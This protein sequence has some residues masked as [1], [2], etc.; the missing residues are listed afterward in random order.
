VSNPAPLSQRSDMV[1]FLNG[2]FIPADQARVGIM[3]HAFS[4]G[5]GCFEGIR[6]YWNAQAGEN[7]LFRLREHFERLHR[8]A[9]ILSVT[10]PYSVDRLM[11]IA[12]ELVRRNDFRENCYLRPCAFKADETIGVKLHGLEDQFSMLAVPMGDYVSTAGL[13][14]GVSSWRRIDDNMIPARGKITGAYVNSA[15]AKSEAQQNG[16]DEAIMLTSEGHVSEGSAEN[17]FLL[18]GNELV[19][20]PPTE[21]I[22]LGITRETVMQL[23]RRELEL[24][25]R[26]RVIDRTELYVADEIILTGTGAQL[27]PVVAVDHRPVGTGEIGPVSRELQRLYG[28]VVRGMRP[29]YMGWLTP[30]FGT[31]A[32]TATATPARAPELVAAADGDKAAGNGHKADKAD[33]ATSNGRA[34]GSHRAR[35]SRQ[36]AATR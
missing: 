22:L 12:V 34:A 17:I 32:T 4:Y 5:T 29:E 30:V 23:A 18:F 13:R 26:E 8:S 10:L 2:E 20:P 27:A 7:Y 21:N 35:A 16:F 15:F 1:V 19:T 31:A 3:S 11:E 14:C 25:V 36:P 28:E 24:I 33:K 9:R 6:G